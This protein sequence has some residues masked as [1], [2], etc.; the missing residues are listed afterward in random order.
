MQK[1]E[2]NHGSTSNMNSGSNT[3]STEE[4][5]IPNLTENFIN[6]KM[7]IIIVFFVEYQFFWI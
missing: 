2:Q 6:S 1:T 7:F 3:F 4:K 5:E